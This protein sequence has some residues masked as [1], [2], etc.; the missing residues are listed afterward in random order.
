M[1]LLPAIDLRG[2]SAVRLVQGDF[3]R[4]QSYGDPLSLAREFVAQGARWLHVVDLDAARTGDPV[5]R[6]IVVAIAR[7]AGVPVQT[8][9]GVRTDDDVESLL[10]AG[11]ARVVL[12]TAA[13]G[14]PSVA[15]RHARRFPGK[16]AVGLDY[17]RSGDGGLAVAVRGWTEEA[18]RS[19]AEVLDVLS[20][21]PLGAVVVTA[22]DR[23]GTLSGPDVEGLSSVLDMTDLP[24]VASGGVGGAGDVASLARL[25]SPVAGRSL[26]GAVVV[27]ALVEGRVSIGEA[28]AACTAS[29]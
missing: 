19:V 1:E 3:S 8:G 6:P 15:V 5:N 22:I 20:G 9:G 11:V 21:A 12:G 16:V 24:V 18:G 26:A 13:L 29:G 17:R 27:K 28:M 10:G 23:D 25:R 14:D 4:E 2:G 7:E